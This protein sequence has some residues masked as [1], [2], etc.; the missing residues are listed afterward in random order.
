MTTSAGAAERAIIVSTSDPVSIRDAD[1]VAAV[2]IEQG[3]KNIRLVI[4]RVRPRLIRKK[5]IY[6][7]DKAIDGAAIQLI[8]VVPEDEQVTVAAFKGIPVVKV[9][10]TGAALAFC[11]IARRIMG[12]E[13]ALMKL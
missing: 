4:N 8:G 10:R 1:R 5:I 7:L 2:V 11:N 9:S 6:D 3:V 13:V 12:E